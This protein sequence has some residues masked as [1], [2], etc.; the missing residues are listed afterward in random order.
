MAI[1]KNRWECSG[2]EARTVSLGACGFALMAVFKNWTLWLKDIDL[3]CQAFNVLF[4][5]K[6]EDALTK[7]S[8]Y[9]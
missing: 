4:Q 8:D 3:L 7:S 5:T 9:T 6:I 1:L 2:R